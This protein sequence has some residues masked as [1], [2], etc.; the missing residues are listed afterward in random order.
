MVR[1]SEGGISGPG[2]EEGNKIEMNFF[3]IGT[4]KRGGR[5]GGI[6]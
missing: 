3:G 6:P 5:N 1:E 2:P 4:R